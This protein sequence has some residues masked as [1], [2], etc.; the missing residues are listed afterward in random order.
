LPGE[1]ELRKCF[2]DPFRRPPLDELG[3][4]HL[5]RPSGE[6]KRVG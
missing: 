1:T 4:A 5:V 3:M 2:V 6:E